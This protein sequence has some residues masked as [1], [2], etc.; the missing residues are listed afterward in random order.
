MGNEICQSY[1]VHVRFCDPELKS[2]CDIYELAAQQ[3][4]PAKE[5]AKAVVDELQAVIK[6]KRAFVRFT[7]PAQLCRSVETTQRVGCGQ[8]KITRKAC[9]PV[10]LKE[11]TVTPNPVV[12]WKPGP[13]Y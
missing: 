2:G 8:T 4:V 5:D 1:K 10:D 7:G 9:E 12:T 13:R 3:C 6:D 11:P